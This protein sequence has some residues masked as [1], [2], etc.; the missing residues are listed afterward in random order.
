M[1][2]ETGMG[3]STLNEVRR[4][5]GHEYCR[6]P[7][8]AYPLRFP[9]DHIIAQQHGGETVLENLALACVRCN[10]YKGPNIAGFDPLTGR[11]TR[12]FHPRRDRWSRHYSWD[13]PS[14]VGRTAVGRATIRLLQINH[15]DSI[16]VRCELIK[17]SRFPPP[18]PRLR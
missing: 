17:E 1:A 11:M 15:P 16:A 14:I 6:L 2:I 5:A 10:S 3:Q 4:R 18:A 7:Q 8:F 13:G 12:L 9:I